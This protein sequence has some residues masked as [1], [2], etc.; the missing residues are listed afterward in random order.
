MFY[1][2]VKNSMP[3]SMTSWWYFRPNNIPACNNQHGA[4]FPLLLPSHT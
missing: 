2:A 4:I 1:H 3:S